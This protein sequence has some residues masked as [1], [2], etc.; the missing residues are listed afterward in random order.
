MHFPNMTVIQQPRNRP[1][2]INFHVVVHGIW[3]RHIIPRVKLFG[4]PSKPIKIF[5][6]YTFAEGRHFV[7]IVLS[8][9]RKT[10]CIV[11][12]D[13]VKTMGTNWLGRRT[14]YHHMIR[15]LICNSAWAQTTVNLI[16]DDHIFHGM[17]KPLRDKS[18]SCSSSQRNAGA[19]YHDFSKT[20]RSFA[21]R[22]LGWLFCSQ[23]VP[24]KRS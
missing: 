11:K 4:A 17:V 12:M 20:T 13:F 2:S 3:D 22:N 6:G 8:T 15:D 23:T 9:T 24:R 18:R 14:L 10:A 16:Q 1:V 21:E 19:D 7:D 5:V